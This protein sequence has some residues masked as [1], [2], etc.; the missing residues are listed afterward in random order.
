[1]SIRIDI[2]FLAHQVAASLPE[3]ER[4]EVMKKAAEE[5]WTVNQVRAE[6]KDRKP[7]PERESWLEITG[8]HG[9]TKPNDNAKQRRERQEQLKAI[10]PGIV[11]PSSEGMLPEMA[12]RL[13]A[14]CKVLVA[15]LNPKKT[16]QDVAEKKET[17]SQRKQREFDQLVQRELARIR[18]VGQKEL[19]EAYAKQNAEFAKREAECEEKEDKARQ[20]ELHADAIN[21]KA[22]DLLH[23]TR[24]VP[25]DVWKKIRRLLHSDRYPEE[26]RAKLDEA[27]GLIN[28]HFERYVLVEPPVPA[29]PISYAEARRRAGKR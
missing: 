12:S 10:D 29:K 18:A 15:Q 3:P 17:L 11:F 7:K 14:A 22:V 8:N 21:K 13:D 5:N 4:I 27:L 28:Q 25:L 19:D 6:V 2:C 20:R 24:G 16:K 1:M 23:S 9:L 26:H